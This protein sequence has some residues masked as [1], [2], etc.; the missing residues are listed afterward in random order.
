MSKQALNTRPAVKSAKKTTSRKAGGKL[1]LP[2]LELAYRTTSRTLEDL[3]TEHGIS[4]ARVC[5]L[6]KELGWSRGDLQQQVRARAEAKVQEQ[7]T[8][9]QAGTEEAIDHT[10][11]VMAG[12]I[13][14]ERRDVG[15]LIAVADK[16][17]IE[18]EGKAPGR[19][20][21]NKDPLAVRID[22]TRKLTN[23]MNSLIELERSVLNITPATPIDASKRVAEAIDNGMAGLKAKFAEA[24]RK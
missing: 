6:A 4:R 7:Q 20:P 10:A 24:L 21:K 8:K 9:V 22:N 2:K 11:T 19:K 12:T 14:R 3:G 23:T 17:L 15:R 5:Q 18:L 13:L 16:L 1:D